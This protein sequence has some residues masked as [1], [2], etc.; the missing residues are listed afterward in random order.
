MGHKGGWFDLQEP[1]SSK[2]V[3][4]KIF[5]KIEE[6]EY[7]KI[8]VTKNNCLGTENI[9]GERAEDFEKRKSS[10]HIG[11]FYREG[12]WQALRRSKHEKKNVYN[13][14]YENEETAAHAS[15]TF[16]RTLMKNGEQILKLNFP[17]D[18]TEVCQKR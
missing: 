1:V 2:K 17:D 15:D 5:V 9:C 10:S 6:D 18:C 11:V 3:G 8:K 13:G 16:A 4:E 14:C 12:R 7:A